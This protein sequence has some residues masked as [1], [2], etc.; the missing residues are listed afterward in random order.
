MIIAQFWALAN[1]I[2]TPEEGKRLFAVVAVGSTLGAI[3]GATVFENLVD[4]EKSA[5]GAVNRMLLLAA[6]ILAVCAVLTRFI[7]NR[8]KVAQA[9]PEDRDESKEK[10]IDPKGGFQLVFGQRYLLLI[11]FLML[12]V[13]LVN[14]TG[15][16]ILG[17]TLE[18]TAAGL[19][20]AGQTSGLAPDEFQEQ[21]I[22][23][24][25]AGFFKWV[26][27][28]TAL[29][30]MFL[31]SRFFKWFGVRAALFVLPVIA[32]GGYG[33]LAFASVTSVLALIRGVK[34]AENSTDY[35]IQNTAR[36]ALFLPT[37]R[38][39]KYKAK[40]VVD[41]FFWR[42]GD[43]LS[44]VLVFV[45][46]QMALGSKQFAAANAILVVIWLLLAIGIAREHKKITEGPAVEGKP[47][48]EPGRA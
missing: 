1:D 29:I 9:T 11:A 14:T 27:W 13:N 20:A 25:Y 8:E 23:N 48:L 35:S 10:P 15:E 4:P 19:V 17:R 40:Q 47:V 43:V 30:Q 37:S 28:L 38:E 2:Y 3:V 41:A 33:M 45:G 7:S 32:L 18:D 31:V 39:A 24:Y 6:G 22:G 36:Q 16:Y 12:M 46:T 34:I 42:S 21:F 5:P 26:N 44:A